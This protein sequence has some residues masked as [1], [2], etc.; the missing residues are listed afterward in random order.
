MNRDFV[1][2]NIHNLDRKIKKP[3]NK[4][5]KYNKLSNQCEKYRQS[6]KRRKCNLDEYIKFSDAKMMK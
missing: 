4:S 1:E 6:Q 2:C 3:C 5:K